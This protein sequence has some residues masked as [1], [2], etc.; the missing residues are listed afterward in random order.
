MTPRERYDTVVIYWMLGRGTDPQVAGFVAALAAALFVRWR[1]R[2][3][4]GIL[5]WLLA[6]GV[7]AAGDLW[8]VV[9]VA[10]VARRP[11][12][13]LTVRG[14]RHAAVGGRAAGAGARRGRGGTRRRTMAA[15]RL[16]VDRAHVPGDCVRRRRHDR[17]QVARS[18]AAT[19][20]AAAPVGLGDSR[21]R[22]VSWLVAHESI[23]RSAGWGWRLSRRP[24]SFTSAARSR[25]TSSGMPTMP[26]RFAPPPR[27]RSE[28]S[29]PTT[30]SRRSCCFRSTIARSCCSP[31]QS[32][33][34]TAS[35]PLL[36][37]HRTGALLVSRNPEPAVGAAA[38]AAR[39]HGHRGGEWCVQV[40]KR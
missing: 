22:L 11:G 28:S 5:I 9:T 19:A 15:A 30:C 20:T 38:A 31:I 36:A 16:R 18:A 17:R 26:R 8:E 13:R 21:H 33:Q 27:R 24:W 2:S 40:W 10:E 3:S 32:S 35:A 25:P 12:S 39:A 1:W 6:F 7:T 34:D 37:E 23:A 29:W 4:I 14:L